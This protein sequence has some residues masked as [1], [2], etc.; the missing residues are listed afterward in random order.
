[1]TRQ[2][3]YKQRK[4]R[5]VRKVDGELIARLVR[6]QRCQHPRIGG[7]KLHKLLSADLADAGISIGRDAFFS[8]LREHGLLVDPLPRAPRT[9]NSQHCLP[10]FRNL[11]RDL[12]PTAPNQI[13]VSDITYLRTEGNF[14]YLA[15]VMDLYSRK[16]VGYHCGDSLES[17]GCV[18][19]LEQALAELPEN[20]FPI[21]HSDRGC[22]Y[23]CH[24]Y[25]K[26]LFLR[27]LSV[28]MTEENHCYENAHAERVNGILKQEYGLRMTFRDGDQARRAVSQAVSLYNN[29]RPHTS[30]QYQVPADVHREAA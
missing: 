1:M 11:I 24:E 22:Q 15:L 3:Y 26:R 13:W 21:H 9:T 25:V 20:R 18:T 19:A 10:V 5:K 8:V 7:R 4:Q 2:N 28:S 6:Q 30:L 17:I 29:R 23:C 14:V 16:I 12:G 27:D